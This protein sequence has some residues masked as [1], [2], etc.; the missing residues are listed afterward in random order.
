MPNL[1]DLLTSWLDL[2][3][4]F[5]PALATRAHVEAHNGRLAGL[6]AEAVKLQV[7]GLRSLA[8]AV[9]LLDVADDAEEID[10]TALLDVLRAHAFRLE[11]EVPQ[12]RNPAAWL[13][14]LADAW[15]SLRVH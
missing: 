11:E 15:Q 6:D 9:E 8:G 14:A 2:R 5:D 7:A 10:R 4:T 1:S 12:R 3:W 13:G